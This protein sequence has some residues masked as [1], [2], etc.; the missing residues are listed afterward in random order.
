[1]ELVHSLNTRLYTYY[2]EKTIGYALHRWIVWVLCIALLIRRIIHV[3]GFY[4]VAYTLGLYILNL[5]LGF[6]SPLVS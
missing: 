4:L 3:Q 5:F 2:I 1:M 6:L